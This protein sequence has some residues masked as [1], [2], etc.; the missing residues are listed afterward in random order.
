MSGQRDEVRFLEWKSAGIITGWVIL[1]VLSSSAALN[2]LD[3]MWEGWFKTLPEG[4]TFVLLGVAA[5]LLFFFTKRQVRRFGRQISAVAVPYDGASLPARPYLICGYSPA[6]V[7][8]DRNPLTLDLGGYARSLADTCTDEAS[9]FTNWQQN[10]RLLNTLKGVK[11][12]YV[13]ENN[14]GQ[15]DRFRAV[16]LKF[17]PDLKL[18]RVEDSP[19]AMADG[20]FVL[21]RNTRS[22]QDPLFPDYENLMYVNTAI[23]RA[24]A[25][26]VEQEPVDRIMAEERSFID[27]T[28]GFKTM[29]IAAAIASLNR[30]II[31]VYVATIRRDGV[32][33]VLGYDAH[34]TIDPR[35]ARWG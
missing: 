10:L 29:S 17:F 11:T 16:V 8:G 13:I 18:F 32:Y 6:L 7:I 14:M 4:P 21:R 19:A 34:L 22:A 24:F 2:R 1:G 9:P 3:F 27:V 12:V 35:G 23:E 20:K 25:M 30:K 33:P 15:F 28:G 31:F 5:V 26:I